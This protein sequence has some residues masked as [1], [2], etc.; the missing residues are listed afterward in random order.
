MAVEPPLCQE[1][2]AMLW[3]WEPQWFALWIPHILCHDVC[4]EICIF[5]PLKRWRIRTASLCMGLWFRVSPPPWK[6]TSKELCG[7]GDPFCK[8]C[9]E[10]P[11]R[12]ESVEILAHVWGFHLFFLWSWQLVTVAIWFFSSP[13]PSYTTNVEKYPF[14][15][16]SSISLGTKKGSLA[17]RQVMLSVSLLFTFSLE[18]W[19][20]YRSDIT[21]K[22]ISSASFHLQNAIG[23][24]QIWL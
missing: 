20:S 11:G 10:V 4:C 1:Y 19:W 17:A 24:S 2:M 13:K 16:G 22:N 21:W 18:V 3:N 15:E 7:S 23:E 9:L 5:A 6:M 8:L 12:R 14:T